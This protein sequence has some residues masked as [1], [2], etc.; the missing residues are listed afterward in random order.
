MNSYLINEK[1]ILREE[2]KM[3]FSAHDMKI[4]KFNEKGFKVVKLIHDNK[5]ISRKKL[6]SLLD[7]DYTNEEI[8][9]LITKMKNNNIIIEYEE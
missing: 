2:D 9:N 4:Y 8:D 1:M 6:F 7:K 3:V 5:Q